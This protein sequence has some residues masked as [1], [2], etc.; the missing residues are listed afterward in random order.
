MQGMPKPAEGCCTA[1]NESV[2][3]RCR[4]TETKGYPKANEAAPLE[5]TANALSSQ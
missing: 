1:P 4:A 3:P 5:S 2:E